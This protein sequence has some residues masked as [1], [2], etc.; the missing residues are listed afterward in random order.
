[1]A[2]LQLAAGSVRRRDRLITSTSLCAGASAGMEAF[3]NMRE[4]QKPN[5]WTKSDHAQH[6]V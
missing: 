6:V 1:M 5:R 2:F 3:I 4:R